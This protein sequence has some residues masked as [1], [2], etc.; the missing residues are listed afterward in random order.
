MHPLFR[1]EELYYQTAKTE[2]TVKSE[3]LGLLL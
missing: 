2:S 3:Q 1:Q